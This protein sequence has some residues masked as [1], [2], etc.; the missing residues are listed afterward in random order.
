[1]VVW[2]HHPDMSDRVCLGLKNVTRM[3]RTFGVYGKSAITHLFDKAVF[4]GWHTASPAAVRKLQNTQRKTCHEFD[5]SG[6]F[7]CSRFQISYVG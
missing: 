1:V 5:E 4:S 6:L 7:E 3:F 2:I